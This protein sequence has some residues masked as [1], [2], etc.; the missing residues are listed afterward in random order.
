MSMDHSEVAAYQA[1]AQ[2]YGDELIGR[3]FYGF[4]TAMQ[5]TTHEEI[6][7]RKTLTEFVV[8]ENLI[9]RW[10]KNWDPVADAA[11]F[12]PRTIMTTP[13]KLDISIVPQEFESSYMGLF[14]KK[15]QSPTDL[16][17]E[18]YILDKLLAKGAQEME[19]SVWDGEEK[20][21][22]A[23]LDN[24]NELFDGY[25]KLVADSITDTSLT[26]TVTGA[27]TAAD[28]VGQIEAVWDGLDA[29]YKKSKTVA[30]VSV[31]HFVNYQ[32][33]YRKDYGKYSDPDNMRQKLDFADCTMIA[34]AGM[35][36][37]DRII[38]TP[39]ENLHLAYDDITDGSM[40]KFQQDKRELNFW[41]DLKLGVQMSYV[42]DGV[43]AVNEQV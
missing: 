33:T 37:S 40:F 42:M 8:G 36:S 17:F 41:M 26:P 13:A 30:W 38:V 43:I 28:I 15:G 3:L 6:K 5:V 21:I 7:G 22:P 11:K 27:L 25:L 29:A 32:R 4:E 2:K 24:L 19:N 35:G 9:K 12:R 18:K 20:A 1:Y 39:P 34:C 31:E 16:P 10:R 14:R 23:P